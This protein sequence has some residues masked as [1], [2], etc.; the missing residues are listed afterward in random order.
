MVSALKEYVILGIK[1]TIPFLISVMEHPEFIKG[2]TFTSFVEKY[3]K[4]WKEEKEDFEREAIVSSGI[5]FFNNLSVKKPAE[6]R[7]YIY[8]PWLEI[9]PWRNS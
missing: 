2:N 1:T 9:G 6:G 5:I 3:F 8:N 4:N 7:K